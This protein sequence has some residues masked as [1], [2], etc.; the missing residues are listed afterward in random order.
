M[1]FNPNFGGV[2]QVAYL[3]LYMYNMQY[4]LV[5]VFVLILVSSPIAHN[6]CR[7]SIFENIPYDQD[8]EQQHT[9]TNVRSS[10]MQS[11]NLCNLEIM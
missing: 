11:W 7:F 4:I 9:C 6:M 10:A 8:R 3:V 2:G 1:P 5:H